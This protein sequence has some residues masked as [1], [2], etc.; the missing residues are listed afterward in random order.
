MLSGCGNDLL[1]EDPQSFLTTEDVY[2]STEGFEIAKNGLYAYARLEFQTWNDRVILQ[3]P[4]NYETLQVGLDICIRGYKDATLSFFENY[5]LNPAITYIFN[6]W[7]WAYGLIAN[8]NQMINY[9]NKPDVNWK[10][11]ANEKY[12]YQAQGKFFRAYAYRYLLY[13]YGDVSWVTV[14]TKDFR[15]DFERTPQK[16]VIQR[17]IEDLEFAI[18]Y[19]KENPDEAIP[20]EPS[21]WAA[22]HL[23]TEFY[24]CNKE[25]EKAETIALNIINSSYFKLMDYRFGYHLNEPGD[26]YSDMFKENNHNRSSGNL[27]SIWVIQ[28]EY[29][30]QGGGD[31]YN[32]WTRRAWVPAYYNI[33]GFVI[34]T[35]Y[36]GMGMGQIRPLEW[37]LDSYSVEDVRNSQFNIRREYFYNSPETK[38]SYLYAKKHEI[39]PLDIN[40]GRCYPTITKFDYG[41]DSN[42]T[43]TGNCKDKTRFR[44][45]ETY[46][47]LAEAYIMQGKIKEA[48]ETINVVRKRA[49]TSLATE[50]EV[51]LDYLLDERA[52]ELIG[53]EIRRFTLARTEKLV[54]RT[55]RYNPVSGPVICDYHNL[56]PVP[57]DVI[58][59]NS[60]IRWK[61]NTGY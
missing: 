44:L 47:F 35:G 3:G 48:T 14:V 12:Y 45:A 22:L 10:K 19:L 36:G 29:N 11:S 18:L 8:A 49:N 37:L 57:Q 5:T 31:S 39:T 60:G 13:L 56:W 53:E 54:E 55:R 41:I 17:V 59:A 24:I 4:C 9:A 32:D 6:R 20:G 42:L 33:E 27:E 25:Y 46:L 1:E 16:E 40:T 28:A 38:Y 30:K 43:F 52:R 15:T 7:N 50:S 51:D 61:N 26:Y 2:T 21:K 58:N 23:L 34:S